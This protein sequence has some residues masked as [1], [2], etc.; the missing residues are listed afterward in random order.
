MSAT[1]FGELDLYA[2]V[3]EDFPFTAQLY[4]SDGATPA[5]LVA[6]DVV[7]CVLSSRENEEPTGVL[8]D[9]A[10][11][12]ASDNDSQVHITATGDAQT[13]EPAEGYVRFAQEDTAAI[14]AAWDDTVLSK[15]LIC[16]LYYVDD[17]ET[18]PADARKIFSRGIIH[19]HRSGA[20]V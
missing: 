19:L 11:D 14:V 10:S 9:I 6:G 17:S 7:H 15:R 13:G 3:T 16:E 2:G 4:A 5:E 12:E 20:S 1:N 8:L 18:D